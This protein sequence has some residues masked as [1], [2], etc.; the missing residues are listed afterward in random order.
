MCIYGLCNV[1]VNELFEFDNGIKVIVMNLE[2]D[3]VGVVL[4]GLMDKIKEG[5]MVKCIKWI[6]FICVGES[7]LGCVI[8]LLGELLDGKGLIG[9]EFYEML[10]ECK[11]FGVIYC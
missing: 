6:V 4:L 1:E 2:E 5:F 7:M 10:L 11:V 9:G 8:D 3:N